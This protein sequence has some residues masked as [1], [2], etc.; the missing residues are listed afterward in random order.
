MSDV[1]K[2]VCD[3]CGEETTATAPYMENNKRAKWWH[4]EVKHEYETK[5]FDT[6]SESCLAKVLRT[7]AARAERVAGGGE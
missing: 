1:R 7:G 2:T 5:R 4:V 3:G 6:C